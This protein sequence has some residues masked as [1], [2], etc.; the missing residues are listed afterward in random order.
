MVHPNDTLIQAYRLLAMSFPL[1]VINNNC[2][3]YMIL[4]TKFLNNILPI[5]FG[6]GHAYLYVYTCRLFLFREY[7]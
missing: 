4:N 3:Y 7:V 1:I 6:G 5:I 2:N